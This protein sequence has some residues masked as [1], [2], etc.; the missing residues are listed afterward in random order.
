V[1]QFKRK[2]QVEGGIA[3]QPLL[4]S[5]NYSD[6]SFMWYQNIGSMLLYFVTKHAC[7][8]RTDR[9][10]IPK[11]ALTYLLGTVKTKMNM[12]LKLESEN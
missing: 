6:Y 2:F 1:G 10:M 8:V 11:S 9:I 4:V 7:D 5:E 12:I 3:H